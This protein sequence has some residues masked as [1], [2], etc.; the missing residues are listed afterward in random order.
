MRK[1]IFIE[2]KAPDYHIYS[3]FQMPRL[4]CYLL[5]ALMKQ[6]GWNV[7][8]VYEEVRKLN[9]KELAEV[10]L[11]GISTITSTAP[12]AY[13]IADEVR[14]KGIPVIMGGPHVSFL[15]EEALEHAD[16]VVR[17]E[18]ERALMDFIDRFEEGEENYTEVPNLSYKKD[19]KIFHNPIAPKIKNL[20]ENPFP[21]SE[22]LKGM[23]QK[24]LRFRLIPIQTSRG[25][26]HDCTF[27]SVTGMFGKAY[28]FRSTQ[29]VIEELRLYDD[30]RNVLF[31][32]DDNFGLNPRRARALLNAM[33]AEKFRFKWS[34]QVRADIARDEELVQLMRKAGC[35]TVYVGFESVN[36]QSLKAMKKGQTVEE[37]IRAVRIF[38]RNHLHIHGMFV[39]G[40]DE[41]DWQTIKKTV[42]FA[43]RAK[44]NSTQFLI[45]TP[46]PGSKLFSQMKAEKRILFKDWGLYDAHHVVFRPR[47]LSEFRLQRAQIFSHKKFY[48][49]RE[50]VKRFFRFQWFDLAVGHYARKLNRLWK[51]KNRTFL[52]VLDLLVAKKNEKVIVDVELRVVLDLA[53]GEHKA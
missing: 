39:Y 31:F 26:P 25:C 15:S 43:R 4:G 11:V 35:R 51:K 24:G 9:F 8:V 6:R 29:N 53:E 32:C 48:S 7:D 27:C 23:T 2:P 40:F 20:D 33:I 47:K 1:I 46:L 30:K 13:R 19:G 22:L 10:D 41:D 21:D 49:I 5:A 37:I 36:P 38:R 45:L 3:K 52:K 14:R 16:F 12:R 34:T 50:G 17:G 42:K 28:R 18:G 44:L